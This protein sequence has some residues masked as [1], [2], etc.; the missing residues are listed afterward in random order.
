MLALFAL[1]M[2]WAGTVRVTW[3]AAALPLGVR[4]PSTE[5]RLRRFLANPAVTV[6]TLWRP[7]LPHLAGALGGPGGG[8]VFDPTP[9]RGDWTV[10]WVGSSSTA[11]CCP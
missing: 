10:L 7:L 1:G 3:V 8:L 4:V 9:Y 2:I 6:E 5:R 11:G